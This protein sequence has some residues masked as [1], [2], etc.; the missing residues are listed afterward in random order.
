MSKHDPLSTNFKVD[1]KTRRKRVIAAR[2][3]ADILNLM[4]IAACF[5]FLYAHN[6][7]D[8]PIFLI[9]CITAGIYLLSR[10]ILY[11]FYIA[12]IEV[13]RRRTDPALL[14]RTDFIKPF[15]WLWSG[16]CL[17]GNF[18]YEKDIRYACVTLFGVPIIPYA[19]YKYCGQNH[20]GW[21]AVKKVK[22]HWM[23]VIYLYL[24]KWSMAFI[25]LF[26]LMVAGGN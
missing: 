5:Y 12:H 3:V 26:L 9:S 25:Y 23:E 20:A 1:S 7:L 21:H 14:F 19:C 10:Y 6:Y 2:I 16:D 4:A 11:P 8:K 15:G 17:L 22:W 24:T 13:S 18:E